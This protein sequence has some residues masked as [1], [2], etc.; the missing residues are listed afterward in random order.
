MFLDQERFKTDVLESAEPV[1]VDFY[2]EWCGP[3]KA[4]APTVE[5][6]AA[7]GYRVCKVDVQS[8]PDLAEQYGV[9]AVP[10]LVILQAGK[11]V[12]RFVGVQSERTLRNALDQV[13]A[14]V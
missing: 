9:S 8:Q 13:R 12:A 6:L 4:L 3:C 10:T 7:D 14:V 11:P 1:L 2:G 5:R